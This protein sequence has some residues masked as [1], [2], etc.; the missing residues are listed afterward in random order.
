MGRLRQLECGV[1][2]GE[3]RPEAGQHSGAAVTD[4]PGPILA[5]RPTGNHSHMIQEHLGVDLST[6]DG[7]DFVLRL[8]LLLQVVDPL[9]LGGV[10]WPCFLLEGRR[11]VLEE[12]FLPAVE[13]RGLQA[14]RKIR[15]RSFW[16][17]R[18]G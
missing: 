2:D 6:Q 15:S 8:D 1:V 17:S 16:A 7:Q 14:Q 4:S 3:G 18:R 10:V 12:L 13:D 9:P 5:S 11:P